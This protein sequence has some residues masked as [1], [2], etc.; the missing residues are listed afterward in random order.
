MINNLTQNRSK[1]PFEASVNMNR[2]LILKS[3][4]K[5]K[6]VTTDDLSSISKLLDK[7]DSF[8]KMKEDSVV[9]VSTIVD[10]WQTKIITDVYDKTKIFF[11]PVVQRTVS[12]LARDENYSEKHLNSVKTLIK[13]IDKT[14]KGIDNITQAVMDSK[15]IKGIINKNSQLNLEDVKKCFEAF[16][17]THSFTNSL[18]AG[19]NPTKKIV[20]LIKAIDKKAKTGTEIRLNVCDIKNKKNNGSHS[21]FVVSYKNGDKV[22]EKSVLLSE[23]F[24]RSLAD[25]MSQT[26]V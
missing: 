7:I 23:L 2:Q 4:S 13:N 24:K 9:E 6:K 22:E 16:S 5:D 11:R 8:S 19:H 21:Y 1:T 26:K 20:N 15:N 25:K 3:L 10:H 17:F 18:E 12:L 14:R